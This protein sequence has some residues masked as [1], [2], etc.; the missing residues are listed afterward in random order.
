MLSV[1][2]TQLLQSRAGFFAAAERSIS[3]GSVPTI[4]EHFPNMSEHLITRSRH[5]TATGSAL[6]IIIFF[7]AENVDDT[8]S[9]STFR[10]CEDMLT[11]S[12]EPRLKVILNILESMEKTEGLA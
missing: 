3:S 5:W 8:R 2:A 1:S 9:G 4:S 11:A 6:L 12:Y 7:D 10:I